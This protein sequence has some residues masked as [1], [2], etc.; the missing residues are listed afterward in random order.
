MRAAG[1]V[2]GLEAAGLDADGG[3]SPEEVARRMAREKTPNEVAAY[4]TWLRLRATMASDARTIPF[5][6]AS[7]D[8]S[9]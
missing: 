6:R 8:P 5:S 7:R 9:R 1:E 2:V 4:R 3:L